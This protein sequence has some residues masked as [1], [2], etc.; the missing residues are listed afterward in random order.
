MT[1][2]SG[3]PN[4]IERLGSAVYPSFAMIAGMQLDVFTNLKDGPKTAEQVADSMG[5]KSAKLEPLLYALVAAELLTASDNRFAN[6]PEASNYLVQSSPNYLKGLGRY[7]WD[8]WH[9]VLRTAESIREGKPKAKIDFTKMSGEEMEAFY[10][11]LSSG[12]MERGRLLI[13]Q[14]DFSGYRNLVDI[15]GGAGGLS[16]AIA[17]SMPAIHATVAELPTIA[18]IAKRN[19][20]AAGMEDRVGVMAADATRD[21]LGGPYDVAVCSAF[22]QILSPEGCRKALGKTAES[23]ERGGDLFVMGAGILDDSRISPP[24]AVAFNLVFLNI[25]DEGR[26]Y[27]ESQHT[28]WFSEAGFGESE[29]TLLSNG[30]SIIKATKL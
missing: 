11:G 1:G 23:L 6:T 5:V 3:Q 27:T 29:R 22:L 16:I 18:P 26:S 10:L 19:I 17:Q 13:S 4:V 20:R 24:S 25:Y 14:Y 9:E 21:S 30:D 2:G 8:R 15:G 28:K 7:Y 12:A